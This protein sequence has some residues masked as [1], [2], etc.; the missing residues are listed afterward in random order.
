MQK[1]RISRHSKNNKVGEFAFPDT[2]TSFKVLVYF[3]HRNN[4]TDQWNRIKN[5]EI[6]QK[7]Y[8]HLIYNFSITVEQQKN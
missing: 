4:Q 5:P 2:K 1:S 3:W 7:I 8:G 6:V